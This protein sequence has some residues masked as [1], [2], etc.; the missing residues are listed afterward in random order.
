MNDAFAD[1]EIRLVR[2]LRYDYRYF[3]TD[4]EQKQRF[5]YERQFGSEFPHVKYYVYRDRTNEYEDVSNN[6]SNNRRQ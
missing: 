3:I 4:E 2:S 6:R 1:G 5:L